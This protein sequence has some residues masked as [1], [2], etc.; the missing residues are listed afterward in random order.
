MRRMERPRDPVT[1]SFDGRPVVAQRGEPVAV[2]LL[3]AGHLVLA[4]SPKFHR[5]RGPSCLRAACDGCL[6]RVD[7]S[8]NTM[9]CRVPAAEGLCVETQNVVGS[10][11]RDILRMAD[12]LFPEGMN[13]HELFAGVP[14]AERVL[15]AFARR[16][17]G[18]GKLPERGSEARSATRRTVDAL[19]VGAGPSGMAAALALASAGRR[20]EVVEEDLAWGGSLLGFG[21]GRGPNHDEVIR[22]WLPLLASFGEAVDAHRIVVRLRTVAAGLYGE[23][24]LVAGNAGVEVVAS[25]TLVLAP[26]AHDGVLAFE[27]NDLPGVMSARAAGRVSS[28]GVSVGDEPVV[29]LAPGGGPVGEAFARTHPGA[30]LVH[31]VPLRAR[32]NTRVRETVIATVAGERQLRCDALVVDAPRAP[33]YE[34][35]AQAGAELVQEARGYVV[36][37]ARGKIRPRMFAVGEVVGTPLEPEALLRE[38]AAIV[39][40]A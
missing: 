1:L 6:A 16:V 17:A 15:Q 38:A 5:P 35:C 37:A 7:G 30:T 2:S 34:L 27:G 22:P 24:L 40:Q 10:R 29:V 13:H 8:P 33:A 28:L 14:G 21:G 19:V 9:T 25:R 26:G 20:V 11:D 3:A 18:L 23:D 39:E 32:G 36:R 31:G 12:W 4:R